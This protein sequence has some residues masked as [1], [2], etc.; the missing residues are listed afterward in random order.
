[1][2]QSSGSDFENEV[3]SLG[4]HEDFE[5]PEVLT[6]ETNDESV[7]NAATYRIAP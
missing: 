4:D 1:L 2:S 3:V 7:P 6:A 5:V